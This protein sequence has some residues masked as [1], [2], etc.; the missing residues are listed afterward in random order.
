MALRL[1]RAL[2]NLGY[3]SRREAHDLV[4][5]GRVTVCGRVERDPAAAVDPADVA[6]DGEALE[7]PHGI[8]AALHKPAGY[9]CSH[10]D[11]DGP[12]VYALLPERWRLRRPQ[13]TTIGRLDADSTGLVLVTDQMALVHE[14]T[15]PK[16]HVAKRYAVEL[17]RA[18]TDRDE[19]VTRFA[20]GSIVLDGKP[21]LPAV[22]EFTAPAAA[23]VVLTEGRHRQLRRMFRA[24]GYTVTS[25]H[26]TQVGGYVLG[27]LPE[28]HWRMVEPLS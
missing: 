17:D 24:C 12:S 27:D 11:R 5:A 14:L 18:V 19:V 13:P 26:R 20:S 10:S 25:L 21:C 16:R 15:S 8:L 28:G 7:A 6:L 23:E 4:R 22:A 3:G 1:D 2:S 9:V